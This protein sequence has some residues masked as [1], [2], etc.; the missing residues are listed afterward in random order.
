MGSYIQTVYPFEDSVALVMN[1]EGRLNGSDLN[2]ALCDEDFCSL[3]PELMKKFEKRFH[4]F[5]MFVRMGCSIM[6]MPLPDEKAKESRYA[7]RNI[8]VLHKNSHALPPSLYC[9]QEVMI[10]AG[11]S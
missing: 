5:E 2:R 11:R 6:A 7:H 3:A 4:R 9:L 1:G 10:Y 8:S